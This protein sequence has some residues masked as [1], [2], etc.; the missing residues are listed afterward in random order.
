MKKFFENNFLNKNSQWNESIIDF[1]SKIE[2]KQERRTFLDQ[3]LKREAEQT[4][5]MTDILTWNALKTPS[6]QVSHY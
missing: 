3:K 2:Q 6:V 5:T 1:Q 4:D